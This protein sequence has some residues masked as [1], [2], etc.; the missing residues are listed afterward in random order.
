MLVAVSAG[1]LGLGAAGAVA[2][3]R[4]GEAAEQA[5]ACRGVPAEE[6]VASPLERRE[7]IV[8]VTEVPRDTSWRGLGAAG[9][10]RV[11][12]RARPGLTA[13]W[14]QRV[15]ECHVAQGAAAGRAGEPDA[16]S[17]LAVPGARVRVQSVGDG[18]AVD[19][20]ASAPAAA[21]EILRR[22]RSL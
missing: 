9:G 21:R 4:A 19:V 13:E 17:P 3:D 18:F 5:G 12:L 10:A 14:L 7:E 20:T 15:L 22:A 11:V 2:H 8:D 1:L 16:R 6:R